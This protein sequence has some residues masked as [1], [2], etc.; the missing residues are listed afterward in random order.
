MISYNPF[1][2]R[3]ELR[4]A[5]SYWLDGIEHLV[6]H[7]RSDILGEVTQSHVDEAVAIL[8]SRLPE[9]FHRRIDERD[10]AILTIALV[11]SYLEDWYS[12]VEQFLTELADE[13]GFFP[14]RC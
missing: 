14:E 6:E 1:R 4:R 13:L 3:D 9:E 11:L 8:E 5:C 7:S 10:I 12:V 2:V